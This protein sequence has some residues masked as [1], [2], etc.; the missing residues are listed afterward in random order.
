MTPRV[1]IADDEAGMRLVLRTHLRRRGWDVDEAVDGTSALHMLEHEEY[2]A[3]VLDHRMPGLSGIE[4]A[5]TTNCEPLTFIFSAYVDPQLQAEA[6]ELGCTSVAK[7]DLDDL[8]RQL[9]EALG[10][11]A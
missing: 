10:A 1:L 4:V 7:T 9:D 6:D 3:V 2:D 8:L 5:R 11:L